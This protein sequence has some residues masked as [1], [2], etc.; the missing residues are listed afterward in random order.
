MEFSDLNLKRLLAEFPVLSK[1]GYLK[2]EERLQKL[3]QLAVE[4]NLIPKNT[5][6]FHIAGTSGK[7]STTMILSKLLQVVEPRVGI[8]LSPF[9]VNV[10]ESFQINNKPVS[11]KDLSSAIDFL[12]SN[13][14]TCRTQFLPSFFEAKVLLAL[15]LFQ[16]ANCTA[17]CLEVGLG[18]RLDGTNIIDQKTCII[19]RLGYDHTEVLGN[20]LEQIA[21]EK[22]GIIKNKNLV[23]ALKTTELSFAVIKKVADKH[24]AELIVVDPKLVKPQILGINRVQFEYTTLDQKK[25]KLELSQ[26]G[27]YQAVNAYLALKAFEY[28]LAKKDLKIIDFKDKIRSQLSSIKMIGRFNILKF[29]AKTV[30]L[31]SAHNVQKLSYF[32]QSLQKLYPRQRFCFILSVKDSK[33]SLSIIKLLKPVAKK[34]YYFTYEQEGG[35]KSH[36]YDQIKQFANK[37]NM[38]INYIDQSKV[39]DLIDAS[40]DQIFVITGSMY[41]LSEILKNNKGIYRSLIQELI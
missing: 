6:V 23:I 1:T 16:K 29:K 9:I 19:N 5:E 32:I 28:Y 17:V 10:E 27:E 31:D 13:I 4:L 21:F 8:F 18:G 11:S 38:P 2:A 36:S 7:G 25:L 39:E 40:Q 33:D 41:G 3:K 35:I 34:L 26:S 15:H 22:A 24:S 20:T 14:N 37:F 12:I 30:I